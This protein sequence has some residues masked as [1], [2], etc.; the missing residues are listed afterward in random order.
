MKIKSLEERKLETVKI[1]G[2]SFTRKN[3][4]VFLLQNFMFNSMLLAV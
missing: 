1:I 3:I 2:V 4:L